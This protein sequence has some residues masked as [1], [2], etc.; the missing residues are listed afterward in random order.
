MFFCSR[1]K[2]PKPDWRV[3][4]V[5][6]RL[7]HAS[8]L[9]VHWTVIHYLVAASLLQTSQT[10]SQGRIRRTMLSEDVVPAFVAVFFGIKTAA[11]TS[12]PLR[13]VL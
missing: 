11:H 3:P 4:I 10:A 9:T 8:A 12:Q 2:E 5:S 1:A 7:G 13:W 6:L